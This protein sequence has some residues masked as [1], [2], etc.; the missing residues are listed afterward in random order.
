V[1]KQLFSRLIFRKQSKKTVLNSPRNILKN[2]L[3]PPAKPRSKNKQR[4]KV[5]HHRSF[6]RLPR[7][8]FRVR[9]QNHQSR[10]IATREL[11]LHST[12]RK[13]RVRATQLFRRNSTLQKNFFPKKTHHFFSKTRPKRKSSWKI[14]AQFFCPENHQHSPV[15]ATPK[16]FTQQL[17]HFRLHPHQARRNHRV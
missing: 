15:S 3:H 14:R 7:P 13:R 6:F 17:I 2:S 11:E 12:R 1:H 8:L 9:L 5:R 10:R 16:L 4:P